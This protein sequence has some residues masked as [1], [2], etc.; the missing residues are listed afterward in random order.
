MI[1]GPMLGATSLILVFPNKRLYFSKKDPLL[2]MFL[3]TFSNN[4]LKKKRVEGL[5]E[6]ISLFSQGRDKVCVHTI[7]PRPQYVGLHWICCCCFEKENL[8]KDFQK[9]CLNGHALNTMKRI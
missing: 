1:T 2:N 6:I 5:L 3:E 7:L 4:A 8:L 9:S